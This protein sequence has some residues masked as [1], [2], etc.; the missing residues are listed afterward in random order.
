MARNHHTRLARALTKQI[1]N[2]G[3]QAALTAVTAAYDAADRPGVRTDDSPE[4]PQVTL[5]LTPNLDYPDRDA[6]AAALTED[7]AMQLF[8][9]MVNR[10]GWGY[11]LMTRA[12]V[13]S[14]WHSDDED[15]EQQREDED[16]SGITDEQWD[17]V[18]GTWAW[19]KGWNNEAMMD[20]AWDLVRDAITDA[21]RELRDATTAVD[22]P[23]VDQPDHGTVPMFHSGCRCQDCRRAAAQATIND[24]LDNNHPGDDEMLQVLGDVVETVGQWD[25]HTHFHDTLYAAQTTTRDGFDW[26]VSA[27]FPDEDN[28]YTKFS[29][30]RSSTIVDEFDDGIRALTRAQFFTLLLDGPDAAQTAWEHAEPH[31]EQ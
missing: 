29:V 2:L 20:V 10:F 31:P 28:R 16:G 18:Q 30:V 13:A 25:T 8:W 11:L 1:P 17:A 21:K 7:Q 24:H 23:A 27:H 6:F 22:Q 12:D 5:T 19:R 3:Y 9:S 15:D 14:N 4:T 26:T